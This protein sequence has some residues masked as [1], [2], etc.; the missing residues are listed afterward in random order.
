MKKLYLAI[1]LVIFQ[2][3]WLASEMKA[4][5]EQRAG[6]AGASELLVNPWVRSSGFANANV[7]SVRG[8]EG[9]F[10]N[11]AG[12]AFVKKTELIFS[13]TVLFKG[14]GIDVNAFGFSQKVGES[15][16]MSLGVMSMDFGEI[17]KTTVDMPDG[18][19]GTFHPQ[20]TNISLAYSKEFSNSIYGGIVVKVIN[21]AISDMNASG[22][23]FDAGVQ[24]VTGKKDQLK[25][26]ITMQNV[27]PT[28][29]FK[30]DGLAI[31][32]T[33]DEHIMTLEQRSADFELP[34]LIRIGLS[35]D[36]EYAEHA[37]TLATNF[38]SNSFTNDQYHFGMEYGFKKMVY[39]RGGYVYEKDI[40][41]SDKRATA[42]TGPT[43]GVSIQIPYD[44][45]KGSII[46]IEYSY[47]HTDPFEGTHSIGARVSL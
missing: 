15:G 47:R 38:T 34:S 39:V 37:L 5:N 30:G 18:G 8:L 9:I 43:A 7:A 42:Y 32:A 13:H 22:V 10:L 20:Y 2:V 3:F 41:D 24:Y 16:V 44:K 26:G 29:K 35:Y 19:I 33:P 6:Q 21:E 45:E 36:F 31:R 40:W 25:F 28:M 14:T 11:V 27:G 46:A 4:G 17:E 1:L 12:A 23:C